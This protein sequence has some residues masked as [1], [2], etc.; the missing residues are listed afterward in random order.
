[1]AINRITFFACGNGDA[2]LIEAHGK[3][4][5]TDINYRAN[6]A[7]DDENDQVPDFAPKIRTACDNDALD[8][9]VLTHP[10]EDHLR[11]FGEVFHL[12]APGD[13][14]DDPD[15]GDVKV[16]VNEIWCSPYSADPNYDT[17]MSKPVLDEIKRRKRLLGTAAGNEDGNRLKIL[18]ATDAEVTT[19]T[20]NID[21]R[22]LAPT[23]AEANIPKAPEGEPRN[24]SNPSSL[25][26]Q[27][28]ITV[29]GQKSQVII[30]GDATVEIWERLKKERKTGELEWHVL[31]APHHCSRRSMGREGADDTFVWSDD[32]IAALSNPVG[33]RPHVVASCRK[34]QAEK[35]PPNP[36]AREKYWE[37]LAND[38]DVTEATK[39]R[40]KCTAVGKN[41]KP[42]DIVFNFTSS[43]P[44][45]A[46]F[47]PTSSIIRPS[48]TDG[49][50]YGHS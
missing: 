29:G 11:G 46:A 23:A 18:N 43:G 24:S 4:I 14:D 20:T 22:L 47:V 8:I 15:E 30:A 32:A 12:G 13:R 49:G 50:G 28:T 26:I 5:M 35:T 48:S 3:T 21:Y 27:W 44:T 17:D 33:A 16:I 6:D 2:S 38:G 41:N 10:D 40:F 7:Q 1:M 25:V 36:K 34:F 39:T 9:F 37:I 19:F 42:E 45:L 31:L